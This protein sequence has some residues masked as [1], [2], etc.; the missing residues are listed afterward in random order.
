MK[1]NYQGRKYQ[2]VKYDPQWVVD[3]HREAEKIESIFGDLALDI[4]HIGSTSVPGMAGKP[5]IDLLVIVDDIKDADPFERQ[6]VNTGYTYNG[7]ILEKG[8]RLYSRGED[9]HQLVNVHI[10]PKNHPDIAEMLEIRDYLRS[11]P[12]EAQAYSELKLEL[13][14]KYP[15]DYGNYR[16]E[17]DAY[18]TKLIE[19]MNYA[20]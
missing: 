1:R 14:E 6:M 5:L 10:F 2:V 19:R 13:F 16:K 4:Q 3:F 20:K 11:N 18:M 9:G 17:K 12:K 7:D 8:S 15:D